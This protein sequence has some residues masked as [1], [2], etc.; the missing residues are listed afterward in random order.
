[1]LVARLD[2]VRRCEQGGQ[3][4]TGCPAEPVPEL[5]GLGGHAAA[6]GGER[7]GGSRVGSQCP[8]GSLDQGV[9][10]EVV[11]SWIQP[12][13]G[14]DRES[15]RCRLLRPV[16]DLVRGVAAAGEVRAVVQAESQQPRMFGARQHRDDDV[17]RGDLRGQCVRG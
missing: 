6:V 16:P 17:S 2:V 14:E 5:V 7:G 15:G 4:A 3:Y 9:G 13:F 10:E 1:M 8:R 11:D 12:D